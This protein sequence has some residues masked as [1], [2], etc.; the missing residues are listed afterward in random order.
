MLI[1]NVNFKRLKWK[2]NTLLQRMLWTLFFIIVYLIGRDVPVFTVPLNESFLETSATTTL[3]NQLLSVSGGQIS[4][5]TLFSLGLS[6]WMSSMILWRFVSVF[7]LMKNVTAAKVNRNQLLLALGIAGIQSYGLTMSM[8]F[9]EFAFWGIQSPFLGRLVTMQLL[10]AGTFS[11]IWLGNANGRRGL[12]GMMIIIITNMILAFITNLMTYFSTGQFM[13]E[14]LAI[15]I[16]A[17]IIVLFILIMLAVITFR[18]EL[19]I[20][21]FRIG[22]NT[23]YSNKSYLPIRILPAGSMPFMYGMTLMMLPV[24]IISIFLKFFPDEP[25]LLYLYQNIGLSQR[26]GALF[27]IILLYLL[28]VGFAYYNYDPYELAKGLRQN[29][30]YIEDI[31]PGRDTQ[32]FLSQ[33]IFIMSQIGAVYVFLVGGLPLL[34]L[35]GQ[36]QSVSIVLLINN[37]FIVATL[38]LTII[39]QINTLRMWK[40]YKDL[41]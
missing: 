7:G 28:S 23:A 18:A 38:M 4:A 16:G 17:L 34:I 3:L 1:M 9:S 39:E 31:V 19:R 30:E 20:P 14:D 10:V 26:I 11:L 5:I 24:Y 33:K 36:D 32:K 40:Q 8:S 21:I 25:H 6:P 41:I 2:N 29:G 12:G 35:A 22:I 13:G 37:G 27:Y 15:R